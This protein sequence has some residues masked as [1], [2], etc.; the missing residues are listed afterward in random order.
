ML[1]SKLLSEWPL[2]IRDLFSIDTEF[3]GMASSR[4]L[5]IE[6]GFADARCGHTKTRHPVNGV[7]RQAEHRPLKVRPTAFTTPALRF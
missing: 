6:H 5:L 7:N 3:V 2:P 1:S 4:Y